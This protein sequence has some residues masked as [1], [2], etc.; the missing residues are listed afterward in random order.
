MQSKVESEINLS[1]FSEETFNIDHSVAR[2][3]EQ[4]DELVQEGRML[5]DFEEDKWIIT[6]SLYIDQ[7]RNYDF[8]IFDSLINKKLPKDFK[9]IVKCWVANLTTIMKGGFYLKFH[10]FTRMFVESKGLRRDYVKHFIK[11]IAHLE[12]KKVIGEGGEMKELTDK[13]KIS[14]IRSLLNFFD[15]S[16]LEVGEIYVPQLVNLLEKLGRGASIKLLPKSNYIL[17]FSYHLNAYFEQLLPLN[18]W[19]SKLNS[20]VRINTLNKKVD[21]ELFSI[22]PLVIWW[23][24]SNLIPMRSSEFC[25]IERECLSIVENRRY[26][27]LPRNKMPKGGE[28]VIDKLLI[29]EE[30]YELISFYIEITK[31]FGRT[32]TLISY[33]S[34]MVMFPDVSGRQRKY[35]RNQFS[36]S[37]LNNLIKSFYIVMQRKFNIKIPKENQITSNSTRHLAFISLMMQGH[38]P[39]EIARLGGHKSITA[40]FSYYN[41]TEHWI[42]CEVYRLM[43]KHKDWAQNSDGSGVVPDEVSNKAIGTI[44]K[45][46]KKLAIGYCKDAEMMRCQSDSHFLCDYWGCEPDE[47]IEHKQTVLEQLNKRKSRIGELTSIIYNI[48]KQIMS[49]SLSKMK[50][51][52]YTDLQTNANSIQSELGNLVKIYK[53]FGEGLIFDEQ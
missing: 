4:L 3:K 6:D 33:R 31:K 15:Y 50:H 5:S 7:R 18:S 27:Q 16:E 19:N 49:D 37:I 39:I 8:S 13:T 24:I 14:Y 45:N 28:Q 51:N 48:N 36:T 40:Q 11:Y 41:H 38:T 34:L 26:I 10:Q 20:G 22:Y 52:L 12:N 21:R 43:Q 29:D 53:K 25:L 23:K 35:N 42:D 2:A 47:F 17:S 46:D 32:D 44:G 9:I 1:A 30:T